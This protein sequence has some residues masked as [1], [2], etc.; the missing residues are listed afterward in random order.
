MG[1]SFIKIHYPEQ[2]RYLHDKGFLYLVRYRGAKNNSIVSIFYNGSNVG[3]GSITVIG[4]VVKRDGE[5]YV[6]DSD[7]DLIPIED[8]QPFSGFDER[9]WIKY[10][11]QKYEK[12]SNRIF[13]V[14]LTLIR[15]YYPFYKALR[16]EQP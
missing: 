7:D 13:L 12:S 11:A 2:L 14:K 16:E 10:V 1:Y 15:A 6:R 8:Y 4:K 5:L 9:T 3:Y